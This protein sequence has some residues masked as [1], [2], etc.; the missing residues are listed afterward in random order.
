MSKEIYQLK[1]EYS[2]YVLILLV[3]NN[4]KKKLVCIR[5]KITK[6]G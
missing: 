4:K 3:A 2:F 1:L 6:E 5:N